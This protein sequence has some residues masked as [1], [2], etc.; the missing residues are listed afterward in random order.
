MTVGSWW[1][2]HGPIEIWVCASAGPME[3]G[4]T[5]GIIKPIIFMTSRY[6]YSSPG[7]F[8]AV[9][10]APNLSEIAAEDFEDGTV[11]INFLTG[12]YFAFNDFG[13]ALWRMSS[14]GVSIAEL[15]D[16]IPSMA[17]QDVPSPEIVARDVSEFFHILIE[18]RLLAELHTED[19]RIE[20][21]IGKPVARYE[22]PAVQIFDDLADL[23]LLDPIH[24]VNEQ[25]GWPVVRNDTERG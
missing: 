17:M 9:I 20:P 11:L 25:L 22:A 1:P 12:K 15:I 7:I 19:M 13:G 14:N 4:K 16:I 2:T 5:T 21:A 23:I 8:M 3:I 18:H 10:Y 6:E 24:D